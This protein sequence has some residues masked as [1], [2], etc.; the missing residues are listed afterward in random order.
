MVGCINSGLIQQEPR[1]KGGESSSSIFVR[2]TYWRDLCFHDKSPTRLHTWWWLL[3]KPWF[4]MVQDIHQLTLL[5][6]GKHLAPGYSFH[7][8]L[9][10]MAPS[11]QHILHT[12]GI[13]GPFLRRLK[14]KALQPCGEVEFYLDGDMVSR[15]EFLADEK[16]TSPRNFPYTFLCFLMVDVQP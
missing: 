5:C 3:S 2:V 6:L 11:K 10:L 7:M 1:W 13:V 9:V 15:A 14:I 8:V 16:K 4:L 12:L